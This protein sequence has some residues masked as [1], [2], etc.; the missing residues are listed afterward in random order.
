MCHTRRPHA[1]HHTVSLSLALAAFAP[2]LLAGCGRPESTENTSQTAPSSTN[3]TVGT[4][5]SEGAGKPIENLKV[6]LVTSGPISDNGWNAGAY[7]GLQEVKAAT[8]A[9]VQNVEAPK[10]PEQ[11]ENLSAFAAKQYHI[12]Y[13]HGAEYEEVALELEKNFPNTLF[14]ISSGRKVGKNTTPIIYHLEDGAYLL[15]ML[16]AGMS[17]SGKIA[18]VGAQDIVP[19]KS[20]FLAFE[21]GAKAVKPDITILPPVYTGSWDDVSKAKDQTLALLDQ[22]ADI[23]IQDVDAAALG[24]FNAVEE[25]AKSGKEV[26]ALG[27][28]SD[29]NGV[30]PSVVLAS[31]PIY[32]DKPFIEIAKQVKA[33]TFK[34]NAQPFGMK[35]GVIDFVLNPQLEAK[36]PADLKKKIE[37][38]KQKIKDG[39]F[40]VPK[41]N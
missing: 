22:G 16:A 3:A 10:A 40:T 32:Y 34:P 6:A 28:N 19:V 25:R 41:G 12:V 8:G 29:Q 37:E 33:G 23:I 39:T 5:G 7:K 18:A 27:T 11:K 36:I 14:V 38:T 24:V 17:K 20:V 2:L 9:E 1:L 21:A 26:Y 35:E 31:A 13:A 4:S 30:K 15:G